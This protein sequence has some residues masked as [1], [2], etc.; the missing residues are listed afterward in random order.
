MTDLRQ[1]ISAALKD[2]EAYSLRE[3]ATRFGGALGYEMAG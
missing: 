1:L 2:F 3:A